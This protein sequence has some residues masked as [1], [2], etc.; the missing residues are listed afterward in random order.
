MWH[1]FSCRALT[2]RGVA[3]VVL[4]SGLAGCA[5]ATIDDAVPLAAVETTAP[6]AEMDRT[7]IRNTGQYPNTN[8]VPDA[9]TEQM[10]AEQKTE[11]LQDLKAKQDRQKSQS[12]DPTAYQ[13]EIERMQD[14]ARNHG[15]EALDEIE[16]GQEP[17]N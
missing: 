9:A 17:A 4:V 15:N 6:T 3:V 8:T 16:N 1:L 10:T 12:T 2:G 5:S 7:R 11:F 13:S 14:L